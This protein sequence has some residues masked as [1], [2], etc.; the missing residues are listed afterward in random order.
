MN[1]IKAATC[2]LFTSTALAGLGLAAPAMAQSTPASK[3]A[4][5]SA[6]VADAN[7]PNVIIVTAQRGGSQRLENVP[8]AIVAVSGEALQTSGVR[9]FQDL[10]VVAPG[11]QISRSGSYTQP[12]IRGVSTTF[13]GGGQE[14]NVA[15]YVD[16]FYT[17]DQLSIN[18]DF[19]NVEDV[20]VLKGP[21]GTLYGRNA[22][23]G[24]ILISTRRPTNT[25]TTDFSVSYAPRFKDKQ[26]QAF[27]AGPLAR[28]IKFSVAGYY[29]DTVGYVRDIN[30]FAPNVVLDPTTYTFGGHNRPI[31]ESALLSRGGDHSAPFRNWSVR[32]KLEFDLG[33]AVKA[34]LSYVHNYVND[35]R[36]FAY[37]AVGNLLNGRPSYNGYPT[38]VNLVDRTSLNFQP[39]NRSESDEYNST[40]AFDLGRSGTLESRTALRT[41]KDFQTYDLDSTAADSGLPN[42]PAAVGTTYIGIQFNTR[43][44]LTQQ[45]DYAG[46]FGP[47]KLLAGLFYYDDH[48]AT[49]SGIEDIGIGSNPTATNLQFKTKAW[50]AYLDGTIK[51]GDKLFVTV[52]GRYSHDEKMLSRERYNNVGVLVPTETTVCYTDAANPVFNASCTFQNFKRAKGNAFTPRAVIRYNLSP[53]TNIYASFSR[54][55]KAPTINTAPPFNALLPE[56]VSAYEV[57]FKTAHGGFRGELSGFYYDYKNN[58]VS[59]LNASSPSV[60]TLIQNSGGAKI[61]GIDATLAYRF[62]ASP[63]NV[64]VGFEYLH[65]R[66]TDFGNATNVIVSPANLN[67]SVIGS[68]TGRRLARAPDFSGSAGFD[69]TLDLAGG[70]LVISGTGTYSSR[71]A[72]Q[73]ASYQ[74]TRVSRNAGG[75]DIAFVP[76]TQGYCAAQSDPLT[77]GRFEE[78]GYFLA[79]AQVGWTDPSKHLTLTVYGDNITDQRYKIITT[80][81]AYHSYTM[82]NEPRT[83]GVR[84]RYRY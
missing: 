4:T 57:G 45:F 2:A 8:A 40:L 7:D 55:F 37:G 47:L 41:Q 25:L 63:L 38:A 15:V 52:G 28:G 64:R 13:A 10:A 53:G 56:T 68:W 67:T 42:T 74:C 83:V 30:G 29:R 58:Q 11:V 54:G 19:A 16:G 32:P 78:N 61:Y 80:G 3:A 48:F 31:T 75:A 23:G 5:N 18:Q 35:P 43:R 77:P 6:N 27:V 39:V 17:S 66:F 22:T 44:T 46:N 24:A 81:F 59:A 82:Y 14:T 12:S 76:G 20:Q 84:M 79:N 1:L 49:P 65:A 72:P 36:A 50:A 9:K 33:S 60:T 34:T 71:Y 21:Q 26:F 73:N 62:P 70:K 69:Y 51:F